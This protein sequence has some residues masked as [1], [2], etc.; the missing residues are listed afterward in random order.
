M[1]RLT[2]SAAMLATLLALSACSGEG[3]DAS[4]AATLPVSGTSA[5]TASPSQASADPLEGNWVLDPVVCEQSKA[6]IAN[7]GYTADDTRGAKVCGYDVFELRFLGGQL[8]IVLDG[9]VG[10]EGTY[11]VSNDRTFTAGDT[12]DE[13]ITYRYKIDGDLL[14]ID[15][16]KDD[17]PES[18][19]PT[20]ADR[21]GENLVQTM[22]YETAPFE[23]VA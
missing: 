4:P 7:A 20:E 21:L 3:N 14:T 23:R 8:V 22:I 19:C 15:M 13:Y 11:S 10:W 16:V 2:R 1:A 17:C 9:D 5:E 12:G 18:I 6:A